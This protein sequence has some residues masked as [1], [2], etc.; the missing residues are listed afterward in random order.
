MKV[1]I[2]PYPEGDEERKVEIRIDDYDVW[3]FD[4]TL[5]H[6]ILPGL[7]LLKQKKNGAPSVDDEDV[8]EELRSTSAKPKK[9]EWDTD[10]FFFDRW[11]YVLDSMIW[12]FEQ[13]M[14]DDDESQFYDH[15]E[16]GELSDIA[17]FGDYIKKIKVDREGLEKHQARKQQGLVLFGKYL[18]NLWW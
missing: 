4:H 7:K 17:N 9:N 18:K 1:F 14:K 15:S 3:S 10:E 11:D 16:A 2:G 12:S 8:P 13:Y 6:I 5:A